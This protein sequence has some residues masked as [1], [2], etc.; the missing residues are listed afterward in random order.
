ME[1]QK[2]IVYIN[3]V[4]STDFPQL[5]ETLEELRCLTAYN[6]TIDAL[7]EYF[8]HVLSIN[9]GIK[10]QSDAETSYEPIQLVR[11][12]DKYDK[13]TFDVLFGR[14]TCKV[15]LPDNQAFPSLW[16]LRNHGE[17]DIRLISCEKLEENDVP[18]SGDLHEWL[19][20]VLKS[21]S[22]L[23]PR[24]VE[25]F[26]KNG[27][28]RVPGVEKPEDLIPWKEED[29]NRL[30]VMSATLR[31]VI[32]T[33]VA[34][35]QSGTSSQEHEVEA[36][37]KKESK[38]ENIAIC[39][40][41]KRFFLYHVARALRRPSIIDNLPYL[42]EEAITTAITEIK[43]DFAGDQLLKDIEEQYMS[44]TVT[45]SKYVR[46]SR[47]ILLYGPPGE[48][49][50]AAASRCLSAEFSDIVS[51]RWCRNWENNSD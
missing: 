27:A 38:A 7:E 20:A 40:N 14:M 16:R 18:A 5:K 47:G 1:V 11:I 17:I 29:Y 21:E 32:M 46:I 26:Y 37:D 34:K 44:Y 13:S 23:D 3:Y 24:C 33:H 6:P 8:R 42:N 25:G 39:H 51:Y 22:I 41:I 49:I 9:K 4:Y 12:S 15:V 19:L 2:V 43:V 30:S 10:M 35:L 50:C 45:R 48:F 28:Y 31:N 36:N